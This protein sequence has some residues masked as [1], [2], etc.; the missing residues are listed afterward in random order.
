MKADSRE[1]ASEGQPAGHRGPIGGPAS[2][3]WRRT[4]VVSLMWAGCAG[5]SAG[6]AHGLMTSGGRSFEAIWPVALPAIVFAAPAIPLLLAVT[7]SHTT[8]LALWCGAV[9]TVWIRLAQLGRIGPWLARGTPV[10][11]ALSYAL[12]LHASFAVNEKVKG[13]ACD[14]EYIAPRDFL[15]GELAGIRAGGAS[16]VCHATSA[17]EALACFLRNRSE[18]LNPRNRTTPAYVRDAVVPCQIELR[19]V[20]PRLIEVLQEPVAGGGFRI[21]SIGVD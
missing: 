11:I 18:A 14:Q 9:W 17:D 10:A 8:A 3:P 15:D 12:V 5:L 1:G 13:D 21:Y 7:S 16:P 6:V 2:V 19:A 4:V 20:G